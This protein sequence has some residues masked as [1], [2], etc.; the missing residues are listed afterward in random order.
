M[1]ARAREPV[2]V[3]PVAGSVGP[4][5]GEG[6]P[7]VTYLHLQLEKLAGDRYEAA[8]QLPLEARDVTVSAI[9]GAAEALGDLPDQPAEAMERLQRLCV[10]HGLS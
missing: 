9:R 6:L 4:Q 5:C 10:T 2:V 8:F 3:L 7:A 1:A